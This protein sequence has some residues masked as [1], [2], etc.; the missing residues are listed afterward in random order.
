MVLWSKTSWAQPSGVEPNDN[1]YRNAA[2]NRTHCDRCGKQ[3]AKDAPVYW[4]GRISTG[5]DYVE[6]NYD[7]W[8]VFDPRGTFVMLC[9]DC[10]NEGR[11]VNAAYDKSVQSL[12][13]QR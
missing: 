11:E 13:A 4:H 8:G 3:K 6:Y 2:F 12:L 9:P 5:D 7:V 1:A 10:A